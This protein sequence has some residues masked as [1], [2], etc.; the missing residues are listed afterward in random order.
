MKLCT[1]T[2]FNNSRHKTFFIT[3]IIIFI[4]DVIFF[5]ETS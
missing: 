1:K 5:A 4:Y 2:N 3:D